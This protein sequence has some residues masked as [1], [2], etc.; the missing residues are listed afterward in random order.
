MKINKYIIGLITTIAALNTY[1]QV[2]KEAV[3][4]FFEKKS[5]PKVIRYQK[6]LKEASEQCFLIYMFSGAEKNSQEFAPIVKQFA[7]KYGWKVIGITLDGKKLEGF[8]DIR[9]DNGISK[10]F[11]INLAPPAVAVINPKKNESRLI[12]CGSVSLDQ[13]EA[14]IM[15]TF[16]EERK[17]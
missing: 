14:S 17:N 1:A 2:P 3:D 4:S 8:E 13:L 12:S 5:D 7:N 6:I 11:N 9:E 10:S 16:E 15:K